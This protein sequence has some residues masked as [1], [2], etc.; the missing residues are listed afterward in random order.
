MG[1]PAATDR[2]TSRTDTTLARDLAPPLQ[3]LRNFAAPEGRRFQLS[4]NRDGPLVF[5]CAPYIPWRSGGTREGGSRWLMNTGG[6]GALTAS[7]K[8]GSLV[9]AAFSLVR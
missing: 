8:N 5:F 3:F 7:Q 9:P 1:Y 2:G 4:L 6:R